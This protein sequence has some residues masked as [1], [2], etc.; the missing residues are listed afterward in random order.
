MAYCIK[1]IFLIGNF[2]LKKN[3]FVFTTQNVFYSH[4]AI[5]IYQKM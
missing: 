1:Q 3:K 2:S 5:T 4:T